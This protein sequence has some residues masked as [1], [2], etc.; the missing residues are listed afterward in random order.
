[1]ND[2][3][4][5]RQQNT[6]ALEAIAGLLRA[7]KWDQIAE[8]WAED[9]VMELPYAMPGTPREFRGR[10][11]IARNQSASLAL[12]SEWATLDFEPHPTVDPDVFFAEYRSE[13]VVRAT[14][15]PY[16]NVYV[17]YFRFCDGK[18]V[19]WKEYFNPSLIR[20]AFKPA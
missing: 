17:G 11:E 12:F 19:H 15:R 1:V 9:G 7:G 4:A 6:V 5:R 20:E 18:L 13:A 16:R 2:V 8:H 10:E 3:E 14:G